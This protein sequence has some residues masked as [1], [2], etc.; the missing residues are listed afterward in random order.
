MFRSNDGGSSFTSI[1]DGLPS[2]DV[3]SLAI[4]GQSPRTLYAGTGAGGVVLDPAAANDVR[5]R[6]VA[7]AFGLF[8]TPAGDRVERP[9]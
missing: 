6:A 5:S 8:A 1:S 4:S 7:A 9:G 2:A 3:V